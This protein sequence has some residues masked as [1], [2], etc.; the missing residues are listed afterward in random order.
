L[1]DARNGARLG[2]TGLP[3]SN[4]TRLASAAARD[5]EQNYSLEGATMNLRRALLVGVFALVAAGAGR[6]QAQCGYGSGGC[7]YGFGAWDVGRLYSVLEQNVPHFAAFPPVYYSVPVPRTYGY[8]PFAYPPGTMTPE[9]VESA[10]PLSVVNPYFSGA[11]EVS[12]AG[13]AAAQAP[14]DRTTKTPAP[15]PVGP[16]LIVNP[17]F[18]RATPS[19]ATR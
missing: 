11:S 6:A 3:A 13:E 12:N 16:Q 10:E 15:R 19:L 8:S 14:A 7:G 1:R 2:T 5:S 9:V 17:Y 4:T 18:E